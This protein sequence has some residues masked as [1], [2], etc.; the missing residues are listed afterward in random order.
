MHTE[1]VENISRMA[2]GRYEVN[3]PWIPGQKLAERNETQSRQR[4]QR[5]EKKL[6]QNM[7]LKEEYEK[8]VAT[9]KESGI[10]E[11]VPDSPTGNHVFYMPH[12]PVIREDAATTK[13]R[14]VFNAS[15]KPHY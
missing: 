12:K 15:A 9:Q 5:V 2:D 3:V 10:I 6:E 14:M 1:F 8:I 13:V 7:K 11:K 4:L